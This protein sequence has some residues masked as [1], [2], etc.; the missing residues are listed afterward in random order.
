MGGDKVYKDECVYSFD[1]P[2]SPGGLYVGLSSFL[3]LSRE[4]VELH[5]RK[6]LEPLYLHIRKTRKPPPPPPSGEEAPLPKKPTR[7]AIGVEGGFDGGVEKVEYEEQHSL[8]ILPEFATITL[9]NTQ[10]PQKVHCSC[11]YLS[12][13][14]HLQQKYTAHTPAIHVHCT[15]AL[16]CITLVVTAAMYI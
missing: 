10:L 9:P 2:E 14:T 7:L 5:Y 13:S 12:Q 15:A 11:T 3:G 1:T 8:V 4:C 6:T 16:Y